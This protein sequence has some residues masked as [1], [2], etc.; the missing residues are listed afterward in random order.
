VLRKVFV[1]CLDYQLFDVLLYTLDAVMRCV[2]LGP[3]HSIILLLCVSK[4]KK[5]AC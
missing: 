4:V 5:L 1:Y 3:M 2:F